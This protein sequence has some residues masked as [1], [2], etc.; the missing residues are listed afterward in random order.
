M[1]ATGIVR[2]ID[3]LGR[4]VIPMELRRKLRWR[5]GAPVEIFTASD[6]II[7]LRKFSTMGEDKE[8][9]KKLAESMAQASKCI[10]C[11]SDMDKIIAVA[12]CSKALF[13]GKE[14]SKELENA[15]N[16]RKVLVSEHMLITDDHY[17]NAYPN[18]VIAPIAP[19]GDVEGAVVLIAKD[20]G[21]SDKEV[22]LARAAA[23]FLANQLSI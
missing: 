21:I 1:V 22:M 11:I 18:T 15:I 8:L 3:H 14:I 5:S 10:A 16:A 2:R 7:C 9:S 13:L 20:A 6:G 19:A 17:C 12:G 4:V 23:L